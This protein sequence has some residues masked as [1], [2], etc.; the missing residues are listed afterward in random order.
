MTRD[1]AWWEAHVTLVPPTPANLLG[2]IT[3]ILLSFRDVERSDAIHL[4]ALAESER[5]RMET[6]DALN[7]ANDATTREETRAE[8]AE[9]R[10]RLF[11]E[12]LE[13]DNSDYRW[14]AEKAERERDE[15]RATKDMHKERQEKEIEL[16]LK[17]ERERD[18]LASDIS[19]LTDCINAIARQAGTGEVDKADLGTM[20]EAMWRVEYRRLAKEMELA[21]ALRDVKQ[22]HYAA[23]ETEGKLEALLATIR[24]AVEAMESLSFADLDVAIAA[25]R[26]KLEEEA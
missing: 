13:H 5:L 6:L 8:K 11:A 26:E 25:C 18:D 7:R 16:R 10:A 2:E 22:L 23:V 17:A 19:S 24:Q 21:E 20:Q 14:R 12:E 9:E 4:E 1:S 3:R 15:A